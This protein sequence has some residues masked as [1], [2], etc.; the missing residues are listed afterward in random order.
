MWEA[1]GSIPAP[2]NN[3]IIISSISPLFARLGNHFL[4][5]K[6]FYTTDWVV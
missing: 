4:G 2:N 5:R 3:I 6:L 1:L